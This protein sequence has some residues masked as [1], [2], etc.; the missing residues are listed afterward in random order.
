MLG[1]SGR[2]HSTHAAALPH[3]HHHVTGI[4]TSCQ[5]EKQHCFREDGHPPGH[6]CVSSTAFGHFKTTSAVHTILE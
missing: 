6:C 1:R 3:T 2:G 4:G 5:K